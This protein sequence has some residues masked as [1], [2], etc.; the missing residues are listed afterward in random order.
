[1]WASWPK[2][3]S[4]T[5]YCSKTVVVEKP[6][7]ILSA[8][9]RPQREGMPIAMLHI[10]KYKF[11]CSPQP[12]RLF[13]HISILFSASFTNKVKFWQCPPRCQWTGGTLP[14]LAS[15]ISPIGIQHVPAQSCSQNTPPPVS[16][17]RANLD[18][19]LQLLTVLIILCSAHILM[20]LL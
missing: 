6:Q 18:D 3:P 7:F 14:L 10:H 12:T 2:V 9:N 11:L 4:D 8:V 19:E 15:H 5:D 17:L 20:N 1:M 16:E 13:P